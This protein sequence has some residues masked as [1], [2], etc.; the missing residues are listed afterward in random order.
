M[1]WFMEQVSIESGFRVTVP[2]NLRSG[3]R[4]GDTLNIT[5]D[6]HGR[7]ILISE[8]R[9]REILGRTAGIWSGRRDIPSDGVNYVNRLRGGKRL[10]RMGVTHRASR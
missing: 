10:R 3:L 2:K 6:H 4:V 9:V 1:E 5:T 8:K 7:I